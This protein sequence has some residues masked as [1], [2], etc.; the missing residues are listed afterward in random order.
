MNARTED[1]GAFAG[2]GGVSRVRAVAAVL[3]L[4]TA[5]IHLSRAFA[6]AEIGML[7]G[8][9]AAGYVVLA[10]LLVI[11]HPTLDRWRNA[12][13]WVAIAYTGVTIALFFLWGAMS[14]DWPLIGFVDKAIEVAIV[15]LLLRDRS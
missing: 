3:M 1:R 15:V 7:F 11:P 8:L 10:A 13:R 6:D 4:A 9:N 12:I 14:G 5:A 2:L